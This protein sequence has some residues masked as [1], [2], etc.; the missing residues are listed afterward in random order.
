MSMENTRL[1]LWAQFMGAS[2]L[3]SFTLPRTR[4]GTILCRNLN[5]GDSLPISINRKR[6]SPTIIDPFSPCDF[7]GGSTNMKGLT[8]RDTTMP[9]IARLVVPGY[10]HHVTQRGNR[11][12]KTFLDSQDYLTYLDLITQA[13]RKAKCE[14]RVYCLMPNH[15]H[16]VVVPEREESLADLFKESH[17][18]Y[19]RRINF[20]KNWRGHLWS[21]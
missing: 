15:V 12:Q 6:H 18:R 7:P 1:S 5:S 19:T 8:C 2:G 16:F 3:S 21:H 4:R 13:K 11:R 17:R 10:P 9:S 14:I 20:R